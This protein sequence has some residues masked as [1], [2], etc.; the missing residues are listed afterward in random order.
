VTVVVA[1]PGYPEAPRTGS[2]ISGAGGDGVLHAGTAV[3]ADGSV[4]S[5]GGRVLSVVG[6]GADLAAARQ[7]AYE[8]VA[9]VRLADAHW[10]SDIALAAVE[11]RIE[12][13]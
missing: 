7:A 8:R 12:V 6:V 11:G 13:P 1:A 5:A 3:G 9:G 2:P 4:V 10:R